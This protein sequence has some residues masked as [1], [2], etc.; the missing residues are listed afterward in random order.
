MKGLVLSMAVWATACSQVGFNDAS[1]GKLDV[2]TGPQQEQFDFNDA[3]TQAKVDILIVDDNSGSMLERQQK[4][5]ARLGPFIDTLGSVDWQIGITT[6]DTTDGPWGLK[7]SF[8]NLKNS[9]GRI[10]SKSTP[11]YADVFKANIVREEIITCTNGVNCPSSDERPLLAVTE[12]ISKRNADNAGFFRPEAS[13]A[14][15]FLSDEDESYAAD[16][17]PTQAQSV[18]NTVRATFGPNKTFAS[19]GIINRPE[20]TACVAANAPYSDGVPHPSYYMEELIKLTGG[21][22]GSVCDADYVTALSA[23]GKAVH[24][25]ASSITLKGLPIPE[26]VKVNVVPYDPD[27]TYVLDGRQIKFNHLPKKGT[28]VTVQYVAH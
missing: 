2:P 11:N 18:I 1:L 9:T 14:V 25:N 4:M 26:S 3:N 12:A 27:L 5:A 24:T 23:I 21:V 6:T 19:Y 28:R 20:D 8:V 10:L 13:L 17:N 16:G 22:S 7:G 15:V